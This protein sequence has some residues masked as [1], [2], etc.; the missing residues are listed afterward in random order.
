MGLFLHYLFIGFKYLG[1]EISNII[2]IV[3]FISEGLFIIKSDY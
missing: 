2:Y 3:L 1:Y